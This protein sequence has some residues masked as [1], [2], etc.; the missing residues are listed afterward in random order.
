MINSFLAFVGASSLLV[1]VVHPYTNKIADF[2]VNLFMSDFW[3]LKFC[4]SLVLLLPLLV[5]KKK[6]SFKL[7][8]SI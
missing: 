6:Q 3:A 7:L 5:L 2:I 1:Y 4:I 8:K